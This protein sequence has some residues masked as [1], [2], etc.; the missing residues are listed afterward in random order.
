MFYW[1]RS[2]LGSK[3]LFFVYSLKIYN[4]THLNKFQQY[5][6]HLWYFKVNR[7]MNENHR[8]LINT[9][10]D[11]LVEETVYEVMKNAWWEYF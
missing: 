9:N 3:L 2:D 4:F 10:I 7:N 8:R 6:K 1:K 11:R 5:F